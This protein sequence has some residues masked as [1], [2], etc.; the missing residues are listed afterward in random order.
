MQTVFRFS[1]GVADPVDPV[2]LQQALD[3]A[4]EQFP[5]FN[6]NLRNGLFWHYLVQSEAKLLVAPE[7]LP[8]CSRLHHGPASTL[9]RVTYHRE[10]INLEVSHMVSD[11]RGAIN[12]FKAIV[13]RY[14]SLRYHVT[15]VPS[16]YAGSDS[17]KAENSFDKFY[18]KDKA[19]A[20]PTTKIFRIPGFQDRSA[21]TFLELHV[22][23]SAVL[24]LAHACGVSLTSYLIALIIVAIRQCMPLR[25]VGRKAIRVDIPVDLRGFY[26]SDTVRN[27]YGMTYVAYVPQDGDGTGDAGIVA[28]RRP[29]S[30]DDDD[31]SAGC[32]PVADIAR[33]VQEQLTTATSRERIAGYMNTM[34]RLEK[35]A[36]LRVAPSAAKDVVLD[37][38]Q[39]MTERQTTTTVSNVGRIVFDP[40]IAEHVRTVSMLTTPAGLNFTVCSFEDDLS[41]GVSSIY[42]E[43]DVT[44][45]L[46][47][48]LAAQGVTGVVNAAGAL[49]EERNNAEM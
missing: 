47:R 35:N 5:S 20:T 4:I 18:E 19:A 31:S 36:V 13:Q 38:A 42:R 12:L 32:A 46:V 41:I 44:K 22:S 33:E 2:L 16:D 43:L 27:F 34:V 28:A 11:G 17:D 40:R 39:K 49:V 45:N 25:A 30:Q 15:G 10:R 7:T 21:P 24:E 9:F 29:S 14:V 37:L 48:L 8:I 3:A 26:G 6:V 1:A 23:A